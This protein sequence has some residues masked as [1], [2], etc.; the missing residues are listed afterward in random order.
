MK[1]Q[2]VNTLATLGLF[3]LALVVSSADC[4]S[5]RNLVRYHPHPRNI[6]PLEMW[7]DLNDPM[8]ENWPELERTWH[9]YFY[10]KSNIWV[11][12]HHDSTGYVEF[13]QLSS[14]SSFVP[15]ERE[16]YLLDS[17]VRNKLAVMREVIGSVR[18]RTI[19]AF[20]VPAS[21][22]PYPGKDVFSIQLEFDDYYNV[23]TMG[24]WLSELTAS[25]RD[26]AARRNSIR[27]VDIYCFM[28]A[29]SVHEDSQQK[30]DVQVTSGRF[31]VGQITGPYIVVDVRGS[32]IAQG[33]G[34]GGAGDQIHV[35]PG[36][37]FL[38]TPS[39]RQRVIVL[40]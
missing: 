25:S 37:Y 19:S 9:S 8:P 38:V 26:S 34:S 1:T 32:T 5:Q 20:R 35:P 13:R 29:T 23:A 21:N 11:E 24:T 10:S 33:V 36:V 15:I 16:D 17:L 2:R 30:S 3:V 27:A 7:Y 12:Y 22:W 14:D 18:V 6:C 40:P 4:V 39:V 28:L 31:D